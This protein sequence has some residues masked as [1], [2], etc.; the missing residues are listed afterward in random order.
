[1]MGRENNCCHFARTM[2]LT[3]AVLSFYIALTSAFA[4][5]RVYKG[6]V[7]VSS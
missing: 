6:Q 1:M 2:K 7:S 3:A 4:P 5:Q